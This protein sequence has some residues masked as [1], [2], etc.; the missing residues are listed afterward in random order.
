MNFKF[1]CFSLE[2]DMVTE[3]PFVNDFIQVVKI[4]EDFVGDM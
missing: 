3:N 4:N 2:Q 1:S